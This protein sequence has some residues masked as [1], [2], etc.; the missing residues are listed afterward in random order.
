MT[1]KKEKESVVKVPV[2]YCSFEGCGRMRWSK[3]LCSGHY[4]QL[5]AGKELK[6]LREHSPRG[7]GSVHGT[8]SSYSNRKCRCDL[9]RAAW[10]AYCAKTKQF[11]AKEVNLDVEG[12]AH[13][14]ESTYQYGCRCATCRSAHNAHSREMSE[15]RRIRKSMPD[16]TVC[17]CCGLEQVKRL[18]TD[19][20]HGTTIIRGLLCH[21]CNTGIGKLGDNIE[22]LE[23]ALAYLR[24][25]DY[26]TI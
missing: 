4:G 20:I 6:P 8:A 11:R 15:I 1:E 2:R 22:G 14:L 25:V 16:Q 13:G 10:N 24:R 21:S 7:E 12:R 9:C 19:H 17:D 26:S 5:H 3:G 18:V 23:K